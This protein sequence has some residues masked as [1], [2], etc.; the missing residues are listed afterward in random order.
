MKIQL[1]KEKGY[2]EYVGLKFDKLFSID[3]NNFAIGTLLPAFFFLLESKGKQRLKLPDS[4]N[5]EGYIATL[6]NHERLEGFNGEDGQRVL[7]KWAKTSLM[8]INKKGRAKQLDQIF[9]L[10]PLTYLTFKAGFPAV[11]T[12]LRSVHTFLYKLMVDALKEQGELQAYKTIREVFRTAF[13][14]GIQGLPE[15]AGKEIDGHYNPDEEVDTETLL[16]ILFMGSFE[17][18]AISQKKEKFS[19]LFSP[20]CEG[21]A[22]RLMQ[23]LLKFVSVFKERMPARELIDNLQT[24]INFELFIYTS[25]LCYGT[26]DLVKTH[27]LPDQYSLEIM[28]TKPEL[29]VDLTQ[30]TKGRSLEIASQCVSRDLQELSNFITTIFRLRL[31]DKLVAKKPSLQKEVKE[32]SPQDYLLKILELASNSQIQAG[33][34]NILGEIYRSN[35]LSE[36]GINSLEEDDEEAGEYDPEVRNFFRRL[37]ERYP[38]DSVARLVAILD[39]AQHNSGVG[40]QTIFWFHHVGGLNKEYGLMR[41]ESK[42]RRSWYYAM[43]NDLLWTL[44]HLAAIRPQTMGQ[45]ETN[46]PERLRLVDFLQFLEERYGILIHCVPQGMESIEANRAARENLSALQKRLRQMGLFENLSDD[47]EAQYITPQY[48]V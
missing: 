41:G 2:K 42:N 24:L 18:I 11:I 37:V 5:I 12:H 29:Y 30:Q 15:T 46:K 26:N 31:L 4:T 19:E 33:A 13:A 3:M 34:D 27:Q 10:Q 22:K 48:R 9:H 21:Q 16:S 14:K 32:L 45:L 28:P 38:E 20:V 36:E 40:A 25:K 43:S 44:V 35:E 47:F 1:P 17:P 6:Q 23:G 7:S 39:E 8:L